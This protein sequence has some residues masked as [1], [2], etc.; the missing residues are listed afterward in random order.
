MVEGGRGSLEIRGPVAKIDYA[1]M[2]DGPSNS[3]LTGFS[4]RHEPAVISPHKYKDPRFPDE[5]DVV[6]G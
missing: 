6:I 4:S 5:P 1:F 2:E 3:D